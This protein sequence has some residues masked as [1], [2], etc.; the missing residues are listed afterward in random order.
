MPKITTR[1]GTAI[2]YRDWGSGPPIVFSHGWPLTGAAWEAQMLFFNDKGYRTVAHDRRG[3]GY[4]D[5]PGSG[6]DVDTWADDLGELINELD[7]RGAI[8]VGHS[9]G[10][11]ELARYI[12]RHGTSRVAKMV[13]LDSIV[14]GMMQRGGIAGGT[15][16]SGVD[17]FRKGV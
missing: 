7:L 6:N 2:F 13:L 16:K 14:P 3:N 5:Q 4:S 9:T 11:G 8:L 17:R 1:D 10:G 12:S 15:P